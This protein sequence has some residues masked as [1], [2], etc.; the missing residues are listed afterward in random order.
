MCRHFEDDFSQLISFLSGV[1]DVVPD[2]HFMRDLTS[3]ICVINSCY[4]ATK[5]KAF[6]QDVKI[7][8][9]LFLFCLSD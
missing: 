3:W 5:N 2:L 7:F 6:L 1:T 8:S 4:I 9:G